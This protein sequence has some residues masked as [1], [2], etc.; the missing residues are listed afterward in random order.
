MKISTKGRYALRMMIDIAENMGDGRIPLKDVSERQGISVK[1]LEQ[2]VTN[3]TRTGLLRSGRGTGGGYTLTKAPEKYT[4]GEI[5]R[6]IEGNL[7]PVACLEDE[8][9][10]CERKAECRT[11]TFWEGLHKTVN[12]YVDSYTLRDFMKNTAAECDFNI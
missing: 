10:G 4:V 11:L 1:Y 5:L 3:L 7:A 12:E 8:V 9:N 2:I 6:A